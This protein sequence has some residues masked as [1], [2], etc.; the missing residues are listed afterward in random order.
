MPKRLHAV[1]GLLLRGGGCGRA[2]DNVVL[3]GA[4][5]V[6][7][8]RELASLLVAAGI[9]EADVLPVGG[10]RQLVLGNMSIRAI[11]ACFVSGTC[12]R[13]CF[14]NSKSLCKTHG[15]D[16]YFAISMAS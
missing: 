2:T 7:A 14:V 3:A 13:I 9:L 12:A 10:V 6:V 11:F 5:A 15:H 1:G 8:K 4:A 16:F